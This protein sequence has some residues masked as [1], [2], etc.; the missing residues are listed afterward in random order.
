MQAQNKSNVKKASKS[1]FISLRGKSFKVKKNI[2][3]NLTF[4]CYDFF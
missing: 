3:S 2:F 1:T 4:L